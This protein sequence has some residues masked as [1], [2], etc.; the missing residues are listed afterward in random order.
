MFVRFLIMV[1]LLCVLFLP[2]LLLGIAGWV[3]AHLVIF[4][5]DAADRFV[6]DADDHSRDNQ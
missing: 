3:I 5:W 4:G 6:T 2:C 1:P